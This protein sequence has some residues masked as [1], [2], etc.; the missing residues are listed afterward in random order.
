[1]RHTTDTILKKT[2]RFIGVATLAM[3]GLQ[4]AHA[5]PF[6]EVYIFGDSLVDAGNIFT[7]TGG[8]VPSAAS[9]A[10]M[11][12]FGDGPTLGDQIGFLAS[13]QPLSTPSLLGG[14]NFAWGGARILPNDFDPMNPL[15]PFDATPDIR[16][17]A[18]A[19]AGS[20]KT[21]DADDLFVVSIGGND[22]FAL[23]NGD[24]RGLT[25][26]QYNEAAATE[27]AETLVDLTIAGAQNILLLGVPDA[28]T[29]PGSQAGGVQAE[30]RALTLALQAAINGALAMEDFS[31][32]DL[33]VTDGLPLTDA[34]FADP[35]AFGFPDGVN[36]A[37]PCIGFGGELGAPD[38]DCSGFFFFDSVHPTA[39]FTELFARDALQ[40]SFG[41]PVA[42]PA[43]L[44]LLG[45]GFAGLM[46]VRRR[47]AA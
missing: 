16:A 28:G 3:T 1:M 43:T 26:A 21:A 37:T 36:T 12:R 9:G 7:V 44:A 45:F 25:A 27:L 14:N 4:Q 47:K 29:S 19:F 6:D 22:I 42:E 39:A 46:T 2:A 23:V 17:Q 38:I 18:A 40:Q 13:G 31:G 32:V 8:A 11:G 35:Q 30:G 34:L 33:F 24:T 10:F 15:F 5:M 41:I 20:G